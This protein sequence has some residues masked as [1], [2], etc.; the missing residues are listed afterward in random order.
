MDTTHSQQK[1]NHE[2][3]FH[4]EKSFQPDRYGYGWESIAGWDLFKR[5][6]TK[7]AWSPIVYRDGKR[8]KTNF[9]YSD[10]LALDIDDGPTLD[11]MINTFQ[12]SA[13]IIGTTRSHRKE[14]LGVI[15][16]R[17]RIVIPWE[18]RITELREYEA[19][20][21]KYINQYDADRAASDGARLL[22]PCVEIAY[23]NDPAEDLELASITAPEPPKE[24]PIRRDAITGNR[25]LP[26][27]MV[28]FLTLG[29][30]FGDGRNVSCF[31]TAKE[32]ATGG[33][34]IAEAIAVISK[35]PFDRKGFSESEL[36]STVRSAYGVTCG[37]CN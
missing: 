2:F 12:D 15:A 23:C 27:H 6:I 13:V 21:R 14:K 35:A 11:E 36:I 33:I 22:W 19:S 1:I 26:R 25:L 32:L 37:R 9:L 10:F 16:D 29:T 20:V 8:A 31:I 17:M 7:V 4:R 3:S 28:E 34:P 18:R 30:V 24:H 5:A